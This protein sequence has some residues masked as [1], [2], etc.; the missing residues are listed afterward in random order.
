[1]CTS[2]DPNTQKLGWDRNQS[3]GGLNDHITDALPRGTVPLTSN[4]VSGTAFRGRVSMG[5]LQWA[6]YY[7]YVAHKMS[8]P[9]PV[10]LT[11]YDP[12]NSIYVAEWGAAHFEQQGSLSRHPCCPKWTVRVPDEEKKAPKSGKNWGGRSQYRILAGLK[13]AS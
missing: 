2:G 12:I 1:M 6:P 5:T 4:I 9:V 13:I 10:V 11:K 7:Q 8:Q 3:A